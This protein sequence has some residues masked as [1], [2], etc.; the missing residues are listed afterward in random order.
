MFSHVGT[1]TPESVF[2]DPGGALPP[3][4]DGVLRDAVRRGCSF[5]TNALVRYGEL[6]Q[7]IL[8]RRRRRLAVLDFRR[9]QRRASEAGA[10]G[11][12]D[13]R[14]RRRK[15]RRGSCRAR[16]GTTCPRF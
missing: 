12:T 6:V 15:K 16:T 10:D 8:F 2:S 5:S 11:T 3:I 13:R 1:I 7:K 14:T 4:V 9:V